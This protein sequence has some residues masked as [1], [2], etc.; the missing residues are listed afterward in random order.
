MILFFGYFFNFEI[1][2][3]HI[4]TKISLEVTHCFHAATGIH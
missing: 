3:Q 4:P 1:D 2:S